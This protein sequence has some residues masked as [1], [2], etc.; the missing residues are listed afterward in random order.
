MGTEIQQNDLDW[1]LC[2]NALYM[3]KMKVRLVSGDSSVFCHFVF[4]QRDRT[5]SSHFYQQLKEICEI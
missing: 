2:N 3:S 1:Q 5:L 4:L